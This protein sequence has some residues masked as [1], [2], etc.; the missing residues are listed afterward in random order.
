MEVLKDDLC[1]ILDLE[2]FFISKAFHVKEFAYYTWNEEHGRHSLP[3]AI[4]YKDFGDED[5]K[6][7]NFVRRKIHGLTYQPIKKKRK[8]KKIREM[9]VLH[10]ILIHSDFFTVSLLLIV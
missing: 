10:T 6:T 2:E 8:G 7:V 1:F 4:P 3:T 9:F 5:T